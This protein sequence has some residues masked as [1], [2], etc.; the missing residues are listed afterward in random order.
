MDKHVNINLSCEEHVLRGWAQ[1]AEG[2]AET[3]GEWKSPVRKW[4]GSQRWPEWEITF[5]LKPRE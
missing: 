5:K 3:R 4:G 1:A 2:K